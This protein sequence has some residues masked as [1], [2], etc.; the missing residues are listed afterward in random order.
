M[1]R[2]LLPVKHSENLKVM[3]DREAVRLV[4]VVDLLAVECLVLLRSGLRRLL[5]LPVLRLLSVV[6][7]ILLI[8]LVAANLPAMLL[9]WGGRLPVMLEAFVM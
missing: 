3:A 1:V 7:H 5:K 4:E 6:Q 9:E 2:L 8:V